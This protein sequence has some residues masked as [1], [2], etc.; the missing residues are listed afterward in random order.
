MLEHGRYDMKAGY[1]EGDKL[2]LTETG[3]QKQFEDV[4]LPF[5]ERTIIEI[6]CI[7][8]INMESI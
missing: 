5:T 4:L 1:S 7:D 3:L 8:R 2:E 6:H